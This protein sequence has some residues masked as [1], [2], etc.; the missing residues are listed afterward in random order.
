MTIKV[1]L[2]PETTANSFYQSG[3]KVAQKLNEDPRFKA[4]CFKEPFRIDDLSRFDVL[5]F[6][7][8]CP[9]YDVL[10]ELKRMGK[11]LILDYQ[12]MFLFPSVYETNQLRKLLKKIYYLNLE[13]KERKRYSLF[14]YCFVSSPVSETIVKDA[15]MKPFFIDRQIYN[16]WNEHHPRRHNDKT[17]DLTIVW[18]G[19]GMNIVQNKDVEPI[20]EA[21]CR[22]YHSKVIY[23]TDAKKT[24][25]SFIEYK[26]WE[27]DEWEK[28][29]ANADIAFRWWNYSNDQYHKDSN[30]IISY[31][32]AGLPVVCRPTLSD[33]RVIKHGETGFF[34]ET[35]DEFGAW[36]EKLIVSP[37]LRRSIG[38]C[39]HKDVWSK[40][41]LEHHVD[42]IKKLITELI[43]V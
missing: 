30:K 39:A 19:V 17:K 8:I 7:K 2:G 28:D 11:K 1:G 9:S 10:K 35:V 15:D 5:V 14:D 18:T 26:K 32:A 29:L 22:K 13:K 21:I 23:L 20:L 3:L 37:D 34:A 24:N 25:N 38:V 43:N 31:M 4:D 16:D 42:H 6:I 40:Y 12:D 36:I 33:K 27:L 41:S